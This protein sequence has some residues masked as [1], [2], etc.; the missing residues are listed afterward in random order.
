[1]RRIVLST[2]EQQVEAFETSVSAGAAAGLLS[3]TPDGQVSIAG[4]QAA[5]ARIDVEPVGSHASSPDSVLQTAR[6]R[7]PYEPRWNSERG[8]S[9]RSARTHAAAR[10]CTDCKTSGMAWCE[11]CVEGDCR[12][13][14]R[15]T[16]RLPVARS[17]VR[18]PVP[19]RGQQHSTQ[20][21]PRV[22]A[23]DI[24][25]D[26]MRQ[27]QAAI[28]ARLARGDTLDTVERELLAPAGLPEE[29]Q[30]ALWVYAWS[31]PKRP[32]LSQCQPR[33]SVWAALANALLTLAG[34]YRF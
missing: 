15:E 26:R 32:A 33:L 6:E 13:I 20:T 19:P 34:I 5:C 23:A 10:Q 8:P 24:A 28:A 29:Q 3:G 16:I 18:A 17:A 11:S 21:S 7:S 2:I 30:N 1:M 22:R 25:P 4:C 9:D 27:L 31:H 14:A 12:P